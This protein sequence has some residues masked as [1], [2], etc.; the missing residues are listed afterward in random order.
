[1][2]AECRRR[3]PA[4]G[5]A[6]AAGL[7][8]IPDRT[9]ASSAGTSS[10]CT[11]ARKEAA[12][13]GKEAIPEEKELVTARNASRIWTGVQHYTARAKWD[14]TGNPC[15][16]RKYGSPFGIRLCRSFRGVGRA[17]GWQGMY[18]IY[19]ACYVTWN[20]VLGAGRGPQNEFKEKGGPNC[21]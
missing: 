20:G 10:G 18:R 13:G 17:S 3:I 16:L 19:V 21:S 8:E 9:W 15:P 2:R 14:E 4:A 6:L 11:G 5:V 1:V 7:P 12:E